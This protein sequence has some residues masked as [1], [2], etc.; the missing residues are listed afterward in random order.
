M[1]RARTSVSPEASQPVDFPSGLSKDQMRK[2][3][4]YE[5]LFELAAEPEMY[6][7]IRRGGTETLKMALEIVNRHD[8]TYEHCEGE[9]QHNNPDQRFRGCD[10]L[11]KSERREFLEKESA[12]TDSSFRIKC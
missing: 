7:D 5:R 3:I 6:F 8:I 9:A 1:R 2:K 12:F 10:V 11:W 4:F